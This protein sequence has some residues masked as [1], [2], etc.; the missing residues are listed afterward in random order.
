MVTGLEVAV[1]F[2]IAWFARKAGKAW[3]RIDGLTDDAMDAGLDKLHDVVMSK[4][5]G[6]SALQQLEAEATSTGEAGTRTQA[7][8]RLALEEAAEQDPTFAA[9][10]EAALTTLQVSAGHHGVAIGRDVRA[11]SGIAIVAPGGTVSVG[12]PDPPEPGGR[13]PRT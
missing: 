11:D 7:R 3:K 10:L 4:L 1:G 13:S 8:V 5:A 6:D 12:R 2:L 9:D